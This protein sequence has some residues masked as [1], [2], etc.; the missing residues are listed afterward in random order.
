MNKGVAVCQNIGSNRVIPGPRSLHVAMGLAVIGAEHAVCMSKQGAVRQNMQ[1]KRVIPGP[2]PPKWLR[3][4][5][6]LLQDLC[7]A[8]DLVC[9]N[10]IMVFAAERA[11]CMSDCVHYVRKFNY[12]GLLQAPELAHGHGISGH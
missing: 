8:P 9:C 11:A 6:S 3:D 7:Q 4:Q 2:R 5:R 10:R 12:G 1:P